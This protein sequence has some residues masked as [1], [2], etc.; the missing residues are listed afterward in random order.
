MNSGSHINL[1]S[2]THFCLQVTYP[3]MSYNTYVLECDD[4]EAT[5]DTSARW[6]DPGVKG[7]E[8]TS[9]CSAPEN[10]NGSTHNRY[11]NNLLPGNI[12]KFKSF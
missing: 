1:T 11:F 7:W 4:S 10:Y 12:R 9:S 5:I 8:E 6:E 3:A 2:I